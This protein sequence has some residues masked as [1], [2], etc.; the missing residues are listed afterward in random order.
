MLDFRQSARDAYVADK[1]GGTYKASNDCGKPVP[2]ITTSQS[3]PSRVSMAC[4]CVQEKTKMNLSSKLKLS[5]STGQTAGPAELE[6][7]VTCAPLF[8]PPRQHIYLLQAMHI[9]ALR[10]S[11]SHK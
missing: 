5:A 6:T 3:V 2:A 11:V 10:S 4:W 7:D 8:S 9:K 1:A